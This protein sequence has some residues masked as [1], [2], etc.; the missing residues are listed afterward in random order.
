M[1]GG[2]GVEAWEGW[3]G[4]QI[5]RFSLTMAWLYIGGTFKRAID[6]KSAYINA[7]PDDRPIPAKVKK[8]DK[9]YFH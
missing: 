9:Q 8:C 5:A 1:P 2:A 7:I 6:L 3:E 4:L